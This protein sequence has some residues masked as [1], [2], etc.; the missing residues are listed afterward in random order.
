MTKANT[1]EGAHFISLFQ[2]ISEGRQGRDL[3]AETEAEA[4]ATVLLSKSCS[5]CFLIQP[6]ITCPGV[7][8]PTVSW[9]LPHQPLTK[10]IHYRL[11]TGQ[12]NG[13][14]FC[15]LKQL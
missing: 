7:V 3:E 13:T 5:A 1:E 2:S 8:P 9:T 14:A 4:M 11:A 6:R 10:K 12:S 15:L